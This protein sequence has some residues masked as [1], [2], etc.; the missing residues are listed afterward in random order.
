MPG[1]PTEAAILF[2]LVVGASCIYAGSW[3]E[4]AGAVFAENEALRWLTDVAGL[5]PAAGG[6]FV[7]GGSAANLSGLVAARYAWRAAD[8]ARLARRALIVA[9]SGAHS[10]I[11]AAARVMDADVLAVPS[12]PDHRLTGVA[13]RQALDELSAEDRRAR[14]GGRGHRGYH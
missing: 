12:G 14:R 1:A 11:S 4:G 9:G 8:T 6:V 2:D 10:S 3:L 5:P 7:S 13:V